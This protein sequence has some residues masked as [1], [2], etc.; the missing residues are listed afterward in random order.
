MLSIT[1]D[2]CCKY[3]M[4]LCTKSFGAKCCKTWCGETSVYLNIARY[5]SIVLLF[6]AVIYQ[7]NIALNWLSCWYIISIAVKIKYKFPNNKVLIYLF[8]SLTWAWFHL[9]I[10]LSIDIDNKMFYLKD[11]NS[12]SVYEQRL[13]DVVKY[14]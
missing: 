3:T 8:H 11:S 10:P 4:L 5:L 2:T 9:Y 13:W 1:F 6:L 7:Y 14:G 12:K